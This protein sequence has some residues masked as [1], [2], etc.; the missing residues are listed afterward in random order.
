VVRHKPRRP[1]PTELWQ[2]G[3]TVFEGVLGRADKW[4]YH[5]VALIEQS[6]D[7]IP[8]PYDIHNFDLKPEISL[9]IQVHLL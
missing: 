2:H 7:N 9:Y 8:R 6:Y 3:F 4:M 5:G 1:C